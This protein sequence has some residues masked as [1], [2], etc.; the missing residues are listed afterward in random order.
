VRGDIEVLFQIALNYAANVQQLGNYPIKL[1]PGRQQERRRMF[2][3]HAF[4]M[5]REAIAD[6]FR[7]VA[8]LWREPE[9]VP[10]HDDSEFRTIAASLDA[11]TF[12]AD[13]FA[14]L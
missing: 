5:L 13:P 8:R 12:P 2:A 6:G 11:L 10:L 14:K 7:D 9:F 4:Q 1:D 3:R